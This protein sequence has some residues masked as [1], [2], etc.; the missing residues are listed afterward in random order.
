MSQDYFGDQNK[1]LIAEN[2]DLK[3]ALKKEKQSHY[4]MCLA[5]TSANEEL[6]L[7]REQLKEQKYKHADL[8]GSY[9]DVVDK[10]VALADKYVAVQEKRL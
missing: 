2:K 5:W 9:L 10:Y 7:S 4:D 8:V 6:R 3:A 1:I